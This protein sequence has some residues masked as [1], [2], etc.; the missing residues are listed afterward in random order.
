ML[1][2]IKEYVAAYGSIENF[3]EHKLTHVVVGAVIIV[4]SLIFG[5]FSQLS[6]IVGFSI[7]AV[8]AVGKEIADYI[9]MKTLDPTNPNNR[10]IFHIFDVIVTILGGVLAYIIM[11]LIG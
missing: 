2:T 10:L 5:H 7:V 9:Q 1:N 3:L 6:A 8:V 11:N 4:F